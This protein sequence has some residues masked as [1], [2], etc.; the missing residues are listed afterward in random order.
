MSQSCCAVGAGGQVWVCCT[1]SRSWACHSQFC[2]CCLSQQVL[3]AGLVEALHTWQCIRERSALFCLWFAIAALL[4][5]MIVRSVEGKDTCRMCG[6]RQ[7]IEASSYYI[8]LP[9]VCRDSRIRTGIGKP[10]VGLLQPSAAVRII[11]KLKI[12]RMFLANACH[13]EW[14]SPHYCAVNFY[15][16]S[17]TMCR[18][19]HCGVSEAH[20]HQPT[21]DP[22]FMFYSFNL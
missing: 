8:M 18:C 7:A 15:N 14:L 19:G 3:A 17:F 10:M 20:P 22:N 13:D 5:T 6:S 9:H 11:G 16:I 21:C 2:L 12:F 1:R 4:L